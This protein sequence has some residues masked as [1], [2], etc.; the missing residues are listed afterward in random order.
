M[1]EKTNMPPNSDEEAFARGVA[2]FRE[3]MGWSQSELARRMTAEGWSTYSQMTVSRTEN[4]E[5]PIR[6]AEARA[7]AKI[8]GTEIEA[9]LHPDRELKSTI[10]LREIDESIKSCWEGLKYSVA[11]LMEQRARWDESVAIARE[12]LDDGAGSP[13]LAALVA[14]SEDV[15]ERTVDNAVNAG[16]QQYRNDVESLDQLVEEEINRQ[17]GK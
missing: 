5:R 4:G 13:D 9:M 3:S 8:F 10:D 16:L 17:R 2:N 6:L 14:R 1:A 7:L 11:A 12:L 15:M